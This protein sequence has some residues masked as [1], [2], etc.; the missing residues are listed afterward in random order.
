MP[1]LD[2]SVHEPRQDSM[3][4]PY[5]ESWLIVMTRIFRFKEW[6]GHKVNRFQSWSFRRNRVSEGQRA[7]LVDVVKFCW[8]LSTIT[9]G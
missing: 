7:K 9:L 1:I 3:N 4:K 6:M 2:A 5:S 8:L